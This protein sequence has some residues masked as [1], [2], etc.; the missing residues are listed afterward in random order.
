MGRFLRDSYAALEGSSGVNWFAAASRPLE[1]SVGALGV[2]KCTR[3]AIAGIM[4][5]TAA[6]D[7]SRSSSGR[8]RRDS[9]A[10]VRRHKVFE[11]LICAIQSQ[12]TRFRGGA[13][14]GKEE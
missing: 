5:R 7:K 4:R 6:C 11:P 9:D 12:P 13:G 1:P 8:S 3:A 10:G 2:L 14:R